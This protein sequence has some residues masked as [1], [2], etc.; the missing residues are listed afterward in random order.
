MSLLEGADLRLI[1]LKK[2]KRLSK[3][4]CKKKAE[5]FR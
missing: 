1:L 2:L 4:V 3:K 5:V